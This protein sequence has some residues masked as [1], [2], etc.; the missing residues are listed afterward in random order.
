MKRSIIILFTLLGMTILAQVEAATIKHRLDNGD[1]ATIVNNSRVIISNPANKTSQVS[2][3]SCISFDKAKAQLKQ[4]Q[5][6]LQQ[7]KNTFMKKDIAYPLAWHN[8]GKQHKFLNATQLSASFDEVFNSHIKTVIAKQDPYRLF[9]NAKG[10]MM[11]EG[12]VWFCKRGIFL[13][14]NP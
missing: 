6:D 12:D 7:D 9:A 14:N 13:V 2:Y 11:N 5:E 1:V 4:M 3:F 8:E 10:I